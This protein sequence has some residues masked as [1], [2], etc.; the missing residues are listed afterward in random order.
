MVLEPLLGRLAVDP[1]I[2]G[3]VQSTYVRRLSLRWREAQRTA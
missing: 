1:T 2:N 3:R